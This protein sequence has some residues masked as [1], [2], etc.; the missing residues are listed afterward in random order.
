MNELEERLVDLLFGVAGSVIVLLAVWGVAAMTGKLQEWNGYGDEI[1]EL[2]EQ[3][4]ALVD[5]VD[6][7]TLTSTDEQIGKT[8]KKL[9]EIRLMREANKNRS[10]D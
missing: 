7:Q 3:Q 6:A 9:S 4:E 5:L 8:L 2:R 10:D 1:D